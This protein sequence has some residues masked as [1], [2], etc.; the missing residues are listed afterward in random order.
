LE[1]VF[2]LDLQN[3]WIAGDSG[4]IIHTS[5]SGVSWG[6]QET[7]VTSLLHHIQFVSPLRGFATGEQG[8]ALET[9]DG[10]ITW[11]IILEDTGIVSNLFHWNDEVVGTRWI[12]NGIY[13]LQSFTGDAGM[14]WSPPIVVG[15]YVNDIW[16][17][18]SLDGIFYWDVGKRGNALWIIDDGIS[19]TAYLGQTEDTL[20]LNAVTLERGVNPLKLWAVG[21]Q[22]WI[23][24]SIDSGLI[25][26]STSSGISSDLNDV[27]FTFN[28]RGWAVGDSGIVLRYDQPT[29]LENLKYYQDRIS[30]QIL[31]PYPNP[32]NPKTT[33][34]FYVP[35][36][37]KVL[38]EVFDLLGQKVK[39]LLNEVKEKGNHT[40]SFDATGLPSGIYIYRLSAGRN[41][42]TK[43][44]VLSK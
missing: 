25:W 11:Q 32:F 14:T 15:F 34:E 31:D 10:G 42:V 28:I 26:Q 21:Q 9:F 16:G 13:S 36:E 37:E 5:D 22:G 2:F 4:T 18:R 6:E 19:S 41:S 38:I 1:D 43:K 33:I 29:D 20:D 8:T 12:T 17:T 23:I 39:T 30:I 7:Q 3:G 24:N 35:I 40:V 27:Y 44:M